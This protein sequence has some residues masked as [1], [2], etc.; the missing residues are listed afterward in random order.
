MLP[1]PGRE[2]GDNGVQSF[3]IYILRFL[4]GKQNPAIF[5]IKYVIKKDARDKEEN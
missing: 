1:G 4:K 2:V 5:Q 3:I